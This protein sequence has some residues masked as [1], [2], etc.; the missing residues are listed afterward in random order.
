M[1]R[2]FIKGV[3]VLSHT[4]KGDQP[5]G[6]AFGYPGMISEG[7]FVRGTPQSRSNPP[8]FQR[9]QHGVGRLGVIYRVPRGSPG[10]CK[11]SVYIVLYHEW[12][13]K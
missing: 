13:P 3:I 11:P 6:V 8:C 5:Q 1:G 4:A 10:M 12:N 7:S 2:D 9:T